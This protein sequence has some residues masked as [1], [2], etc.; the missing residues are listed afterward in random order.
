MHLMLALLTLQTSLGTVL[1][2]R[3]KELISQSISWLQST[4]IYFFTI[5]KEKSFKDVRPQTNT[6]AVLL[7]VG[8]KSIRIS[9]PLLNLRLLFSV[10]NKSICVFKIQQMGFS[11]QSDPF[12]RILS[13]MCQLDAQASVQPH[14]K[15]VFSKIGLGH[16][17]LLL[18][19]LPLHCIPPNPLFCQVTHII[20]PS[21]G[22][23][24]E[25][26]SR[27]G[28][29]AL[30]V[31]HPWKTV[32]SSGNAEGKPIPNASDQSLRMEGPQ[33][34][35]TT[36]SYWSSVSSEVRPGGLELCHVLKPCRNWDCTASPDNL[37]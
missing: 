21:L 20:F 12:V 30:S 25:L 7:R 26:S 18:S 19:V 8:S 13:S 17:T 3:R 11:S 35:P 6:T 22:P 37:F 9:L 24:S 34:I 27:E 32:T 33:E 2:N 4:D 16:I 1:L 28:W 36:T 10:S 15:T 5:L 31:K 29:F 23:Q 14:F